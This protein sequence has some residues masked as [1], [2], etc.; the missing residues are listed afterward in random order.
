VVAHRASGALGGDPHGRHLHQVADQGD[1]P[2][3]AGAVGGAAEHEPQRVAEQF[4]EAGHAG[5]H[6]RAGAERAEARP[7]DRA[8]ACGPDWYAFTPSFKGV[9]LEGLEVAFRVRSIRRMR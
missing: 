2:V 7:D 5:H 8:R 4:A 6:Q 9:L 3:R 1:R